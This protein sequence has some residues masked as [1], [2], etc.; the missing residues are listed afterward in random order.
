MCGA[1][2]IRRSEAKG[3]QEAAHH[4]LTNQAEKTE[5]NREICVDRTIW[6]S[7]RREMN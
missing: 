6:R 7:H 1:E 5:N 3:L 4:H 2:E